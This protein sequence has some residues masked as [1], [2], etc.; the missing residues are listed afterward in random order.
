MVSRSRCSFEPG[1]VIST[2]IEIL[3][4]GALG[5]TYGQSILEKEIALDGAAVGVNFVTFDEGFHHRHMRLRGI[6]AGSANP[7]GCAG[8]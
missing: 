2:N 8:Y 7:G 6:G 5:E 3:D 4:T 1:L